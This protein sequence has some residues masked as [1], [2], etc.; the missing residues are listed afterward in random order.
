MQTTI[1]TAKLDK[2][3]SVTSRALEQVKTALNADRKKEAAEVL[4]MAQRYYDDAHFFLKKG[5]AVTAKKVSQYLLPRYQQGGRKVHAA[6]VYGTE[7]ASLETKLQNQDLTD[8]TLD[9]YHGFW[10]LGSNRELN[11]VI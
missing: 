9:F 5:D 11:R 7:H 3:F 8:A 1:T 6:L 4:D 10:G 2:Y